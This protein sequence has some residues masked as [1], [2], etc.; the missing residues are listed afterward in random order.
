MK[1]GVLSFQTNSM[2]EYVIVGFPADANNKAGGASWRLTLLLIAGILLLVGAGFVLYWF[3]LRAPQPAKKKEIVQ[4][5]VQ[6][7]IRVEPESDADIFSGRTDIDIATK[8]SENNEQ[9]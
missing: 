5:D 4:E 2:G 3:V 8:E 1:D 6:P 9:E 7:L